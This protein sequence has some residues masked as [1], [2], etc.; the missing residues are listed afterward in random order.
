MKN[1]KE[2]YTAALNQ[3]KALPTHINGELQETY[4]FFKEDKYFA[5]IMNSENANPVVVFETLN[6]RSS[7]ATRFYIK[8]VPTYLED[9]NLKKMKDWKK[10][11]MFHKAWRRT[12]VNITDVTFDI[13]GIKRKTTHLPAGVLIS[14]VKFIK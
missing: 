8:T 5:T 1:L 4:K 9:G 2:T 13:V 14:N 7:G 10:V 6:P 11:L 12:D 3:A